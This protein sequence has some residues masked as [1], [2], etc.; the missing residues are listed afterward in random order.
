MSF[1]KHIAVDYAKVKPS[2]MKMQGISELT[3]LEHF[4]LYNG[5][6]NKYNEIMEETAKLTN[7][8][9]KAGQITFSK[10]RSLKTALAFAIGGVLNH[11]VYLVILGK[12][13]Q[14]KRNVINPYRKDF[15]SLND[16]KLKFVVLQWVLE[17]GHF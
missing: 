11:E 6:V 8:E 4:K 3:M 12:W 9:V 10:I 7:D 5:Y 14:A 13:R 17:A 16:S 1:E 15:G 2:V